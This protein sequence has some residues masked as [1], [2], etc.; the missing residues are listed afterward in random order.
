VFR[1]RRQRQKDEAQK[2]KLF[3]ARYLRY[4]TRFNS[5]FMPRILVLLLTA[6]VLLSFQQPQ[7]KI[8]LEER[9]KKLIKEISTTSKLLNQTKEDRQ[10]ALDKLYTLQKQIQNRQQL[11]LTLEEEIAMTSERLERDYTVVEALQTDINRLKSEYGKT[12]RKTQRFRSTIQPADVCLIIRKRRPGLS[13]LAI[14]AA[15]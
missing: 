5:F 7:K 13:P 10:A 3:R 15:I 9:R 11:V 14:P 1:Q 4:P 6:I 12:I 2:N 8:S